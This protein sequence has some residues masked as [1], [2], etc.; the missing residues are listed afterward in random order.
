MVSYH[1][2]HIIQISQNITAAG[3][4]TH[5]HSTPSVQLHQSPTR[6][7]DGDTETGRLTDQNPLWGH[8]EGQMGEMCGCSSL[9]W[10]H[11]AA[12]L[13]HSFISSSD[14]FMWGQQQ[15]DGDIQIGAEHQLLESL[16]LFPEP[17]RGGWQDASWRLTLSS[18]CHY[19]LH[20]MIL[21]LFWVFKKR[22]DKLDR[23]VR[24]YIRKREIETSHEPDF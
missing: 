14:W 6:P 23:L 16:R 9:T 15:S 20:S 17:N 4:A 22:Q 19:L 18:P 11:V 3:A 1:F 2:H 12:R 21:V 24:G 13:S 10:K 7:L 5:I 8:D